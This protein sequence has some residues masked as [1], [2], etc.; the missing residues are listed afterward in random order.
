MTSAPQNIHSL[1]RRELDNTLIKL[2]ELLGPSFSIGA[3][4]SST[5][6]AENI[7]SIIAEAAVSAG[8]I[9]NTMRFG[10]KFNSVTPEVIK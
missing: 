5:A 2:L 3:S 8:C 10:K 6:N 1:E 9:C 7:L 4:T